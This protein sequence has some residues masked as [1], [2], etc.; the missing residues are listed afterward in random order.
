MVTPC[1]Q[2]AAIS[3][4]LSGDPQPAARGASAA[5]WEL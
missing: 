2:L 1:H 5:S 3:S 4:Q